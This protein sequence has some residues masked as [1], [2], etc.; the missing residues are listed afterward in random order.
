[1]KSMLRG[2]SARSVRSVGTNGTVIAQIQRETEK[3]VQ[4]EQDMED[5]ARERKEAQL[6][7]LRKLETI[8]KMRQL[9]GRMP[10]KIPRYG[11]HLVKDNEHHLFMSPFLASNGHA[12]SKFGQVCPN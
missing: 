2:D 11:L 6:E 1:M 9:V 5:L 3:I 12:S 7:N 4:A 8:G 10:P